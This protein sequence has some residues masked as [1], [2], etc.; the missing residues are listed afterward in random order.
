MKFT[1]FTKYAGEPAD[2]VYLEELV[3]RL[4]DFFLRSGFESQYYGVS[5]FDPEK[6]MEALRQ[7]ILRALSEGDLL[8]EDLLDQ[9]TKGA[10][11]KSDQ[12]LK[13]LIDRLIERMM[14]EGYINGP[15]PQITPNSVDQVRVGQSANLRF[16]AF[17]QRTTPEIK[18]VVSRV[19]A[20]ATVDQKNNASFYVIRI[21][22]SDQELALLGNVKLVPGMPVESFVQTD[23]RTIVSYLTKPLFDQTARAFREN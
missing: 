9:L 2:S 15:P 20:D 10:S 16:T 14:E 12:E 8:P 23:P 18:G 6:T 11:A 21:E 19:A 22:V 1:K 5:E 3:K 13:E 7:A 17:N 4:G